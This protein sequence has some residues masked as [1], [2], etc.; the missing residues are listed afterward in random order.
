MHDSPARYIDLLIT[1][2]NFTLNSGREPVLCDNLR[3]IAQ[4]CQHAII[5]SG[6]ATRM[7]AE[8]SPTLRADLMMQMMLL[9]EDDDRI[10]PGTV[11]VT[12]ETPLSGRLLI[13]AATEDF[14]HEPL[15][16]EVTLND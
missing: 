6:L 9:V 15:R 3:S 4:D 1:D 10:V 13:L 8:K 11:S 5:E 2:R 16:F 12:E 14:R 7:L